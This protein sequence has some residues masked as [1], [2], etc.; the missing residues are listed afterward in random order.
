MSVSFYVFIALLP[1]QE[2]G[3]RAA[4]DRGSSSII[5]GDSEYKNGQLFCF[6]LFRCFG[7]QM[8]GGHHITPSM[9][10]TGTGTGD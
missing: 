10:G 9:L 4:Q 1:W 3:N 6:F 7:A 8:A 5:S 2:A